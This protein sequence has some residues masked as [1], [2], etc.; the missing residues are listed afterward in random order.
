MKNSEANL[1]FLVP[2]W[3]TIALGN[4]GIGYWF[5]YYNVMTGILHSQYQ[6]KDEQVIGNEDLF[7]SLISGLIPLGAIPG[8]LISGLLV[9]K[10]RRFAMI[11]ISLVMIG[12]S[13]TTMIFNMWALIIGRILMG[14]AVGMYLTVWPMFITEV[15]PESLLGPLGC[16]NQLNL[17]AGLILATGIAF[18]MPLPDDNEALTTGRWRIIFILPGI[19]SAIQILL[20]L[21]L[22]RY[23]T[24]TFYKKIGAMKKYNKIMSFIYKDFEEEE[25]SKDSKKEKTKTSPASSEHNHSVEK[26]KNNHPSMETEVHHPHIE[27]DQE[28]PEEP[29]IEE[30]GAEAKKPEITDYWFP[31]YRRAL[32][33][34]WMLSLFHQTTFINGVTFFSNEIFTEDKEGDSAERLARIGTFGVSVV[35]F[36][37]T[38]TS[39][40]LW[41]YFKW[42][43]F[44]QVSEIVM[45]IWLGLSGIA[46]II[47]S[48]IGII[49]FTLVYIFAFDWGFGPLLW[50]YC[51]EVMDGFGWSMV[52]VINMFFTWVF[53]TFSNLGFKHLTPPGMYFGLVV[54]QIICILFVWKYVPETKG[55]HK[56]ELIDKRIK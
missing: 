16:L 30:G 46:A 21:T 23:D 24:P 42:L 8:S 11:V 31:S 22:Y 10:G 5:A 4:L 7:N 35:G 25:V 51:S 9:T 33:V 36:I 39:M 1:W 44:I 41:K 48:Q 15:S 20:F 52:G 47:G 6:H 13:L 14:L 43:T 19:F 55:R 50:I 29:D 34:C 17:V 3:L 28:V 37:G 49:G 18:I 40:F 26:N 45:A 12:G 38:A 32:F 54:V 56:E 53:A 27:N 2:Q